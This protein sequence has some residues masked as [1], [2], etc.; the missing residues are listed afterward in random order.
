MET[1]QRLRSADRDL[2]TQQTAVSEAGVEKLKIEEGLRNL[3]AD[4]DRLQEQLIRAIN[5]QDQATEA[6]RE[7]SAQTA[8]RPRAV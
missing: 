2:E 4:R 7:T 1:D 6:A 5:A 3:L 8:T